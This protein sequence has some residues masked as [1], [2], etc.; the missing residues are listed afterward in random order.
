MGATNRHGP[1]RTG[2]SHH[3]SRHGPGARRTPCIPA[4][5]ARTRSRIS[6]WREAFYRRIDVELIKSRVMRGL[7]TPSAL[8]VAPQVFA[9]SKDFTTRPKSDPD[10]AKKLMTD[11]G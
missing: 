3:L 9:L 10:G 5:R 6:A 4:S 2:D 7:S 1:D 11:A 8:M